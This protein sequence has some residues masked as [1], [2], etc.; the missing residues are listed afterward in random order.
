MEKNTLIKLIELHIADSRP[1][2]VF[3]AIDY[4]HIAELNTVHQILSRLEKDGKIKRIIQGLYYVPKFS[5]LLQE[6]EEPS[7]NEIAFAIARK[8]R[9]AIVP[10]GNTA[11]NQLGL[12]TQV[13][14]KWSYIS[15]GPYADFS[16]KNIVIE[17]KH[18]T[19]KQIS[20]MSYKTSLLIQALKS[21]GKEN[22]THQ[23]LQKLSER[24]TAEEKEKI[25][26]ESRYTTSWIY[27]KIKVICKEK[28]VVN[29]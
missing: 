5:E 11:L 23:D 2:Y 24:F 27:D 4:T 3:S 28:E 19:T 21:L 7:P 15:S 26:A 18:R 1:G 14:A 25:L 12:S 22:V 13:S 6:N 29:V 16:Y 17:F 20:D 10:E 8:N 9:W